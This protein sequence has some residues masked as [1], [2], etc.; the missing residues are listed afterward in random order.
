MIPRICIPLVDVF[1]RIK[2]SLVML[3]L[4]PLEVLRQNV[5]LYIHVDRGP[6]ACQ[7]APFSLKRV[8]SYLILFGSITLYRVLFNKSGTVV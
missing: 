8:C 2:S 1:L 4:S 7:T 3:H 6:R 5:K